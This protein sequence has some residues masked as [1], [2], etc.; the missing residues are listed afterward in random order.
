MVL[1]C[2]RR[3]AIR[4]I[5]SPH[6]LGDAVEQLSALDYGL[7]VA[8]LLADAPLNELGPGEPVAAAR[9]W[10]EELTPSSVVAPRA[11]VDREMG[12]ACCAALW[13]RF[14]F[15]DRSHQISQ[16]IDTAEG[17]YWHAVMHRREP[18]FFNS[19]YWF[20]RA[21][22]HE[23]FDTLVKEARHLAEQELATPGRQNRL[24]NQIGFLARQTTWD[25]L[26]LVDLCELALDASP[27][28]HTFCRKLQQLEWQLMFDYCY[29]RA[30]E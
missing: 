11:L 20:R 2:R 21:G 24:G 7:T 6:E 28:L 26:A 25:P 22:R 15:L 16:S 29:R 19:K 9:G 5:C 30:A 3:N 1:T 14:D 23:L 18:D 27:P 4:R 10:L 12:A 8:R 13:L 17:S